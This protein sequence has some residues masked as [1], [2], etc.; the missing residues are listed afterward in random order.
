MYVD[1]KSVQFSD[2][3]KDSV[4]DGT[5]TKIKEN[6]HT[7]IW[8]LQ[9]KEYLDENG[10]EEPNEVFVTEIP[11]K[12]HDDPRVIEAKKDELRKWKDF[13]A[14]E[15]V[16]FDNQH[17]LTTRWVVTEKEGGKAKSRLCV[18][19]FQEK[20]YPQSD[21]PTAQKE[22]FKIFLAA[23]A[24]E[25]F[26][27]KTLDVTSAFLQGY[28]LERD[29]YVWPPPEC[30]TEG[31]VWKL[32]KSCYGLYDASRRWFMAVKEQ[33]LELKM[34]SLSGDDAL[35][36][37]IEDGKLIGMC[38]L[39]VDD[40]LIGGTPDFLN[41]IERKLKGRFTFGKIEL[42]KFKYTGLNIE[43][44]EE[45]I[46]IDQNEYIQS[47]KPIEI[48]KC[49]DKNEKLSAKKFKEYR[50]LTGQ[51][52]WAAENTRPDIA[53]DVRELST[54]NKAATYEDLRTANKVLKKAQMENVSIRYGKL[55]NWKD[56]KLVAFT[57]SSY[58]NAEDGTKSVG[59]RFLAIANNKGKCNPIAWKSKTIQQ[60]CKSVK[61]AETRSLELGME[62]GIY[63]AQTFHELYTGKVHGGQIPVEMK[64]DS[65][66]LMDSI[67]SSKQVD[68]KTIRHIVAWIKQQRDEKFVKDI[69]WITSEEMLAD[70]FTKKN[71][72][73]DHILQTVVEGNL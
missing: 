41:R 66:T 22:S 69:E 31:I 8:F 24:N 58:R 72:N 10:F 56:L 52:S 44:N 43:Q 45:G 57:D 25:G 35:F 61:S 19:G 68:E 12:F 54:R 47:I 59:G 14:Y 20:E 50:A 15:E 2:D 37:L 38:N 34:K 36:Y 21:S 53:Y 9:N 67:D 4:D 32:K 33:L 63:V 16:D 64:I 60:V 29:V 65:K 40:F 26:K 18:R 28:P 13:D 30:K 5:K 39:H 6:E 1:G 11:A 42:Q 17:V 46:F 51:L 23:A 3:D 70:V 49:K 7:G 73:T 71:V 55:G 62:D 27:I 48:V